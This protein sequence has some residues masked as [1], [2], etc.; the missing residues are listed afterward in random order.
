MQYIRKKT[1]AKMWLRQIKYIDTEIKSLKCEQNRL[2]SKGLIS[3]PSP[4]AGSSHSGYENS[5]ESRFV[6]YA[7]YSEL[8]SERIRELYDLKAD[9]HT[10]IEAVPNSIHR[11]V[12]REHYVN[13]KE[14]LAIATELDKSYDHVVHNLHP[15]ALRAVRVPEKY[16]TN[17][18][19]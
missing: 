6:E 18:Y 12:L 11:I 15:S 8:I 7:R 3:C 14:F 9:I 5:S 19:E 4:A 10:A 13:G 1:P 17:K 16:R 2:L